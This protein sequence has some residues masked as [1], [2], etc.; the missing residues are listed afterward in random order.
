MWHDI[1]SMNAVSGAL[2]ALF[3]LAWLVA[4]L[5]WL[6][7]RPMFTLR[8][9]RVEALG[10]A[11]LRRVSQTTIKGTAIP[12]IKGNFFTADLDSVRQAFETVP[13]V[14]RAAV[15][16]EWPDKLVV[17]LEEH[18]PL[19][20]WGEDGRLVSV[21]GDVF[22]ANL[23]EAEEDGKLPEFSG[24]EGSEKDVVRRYADMQSWFA[25]L[26]LQPESVQLSGRYAWSVKLDNG[27]ALELGRE[28]TA[29]TLHQRVER[30]VKVYPQLIGKWQGGIESIDLRYANGLALKAVALPSSQPS[31]GKKS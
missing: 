17:S 22:T 6:A 9:I 15:R 29:D 12:R 3:A 26:K 24:P 27:M 25:P 10:E 1:K 11:P 4:G 16:R 28:P 19:G 2:Y 18:V 13:W 23:E 14:R 8:A 30:L 21:K 5:W 7:Q 31:K 20:T